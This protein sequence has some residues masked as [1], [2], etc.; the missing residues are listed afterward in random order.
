MSILTRPSSA[1]HMSI[2]YITAGALI[3]VWSGTWCWYLT[4]H[5]PTTDTPWFWCWGLILTGLVL[6]GVGVTLGQIGRAARDAELPPV[7]VIAAV[8]QTE[9]AAAVVAPVLAAVPPAPLV[10]APVAEPLAAAPAAVEFARVAPGR[11]GLSQ[12]PS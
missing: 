7:E 6:V 3:D 1:V 11:H 9:K 10:G 2:I 5:P 8:A 12:R 4:M